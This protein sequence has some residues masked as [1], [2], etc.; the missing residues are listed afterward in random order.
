[1]ESKAK[2]LCNLSDRKRSL[3]FV[4]SD[5]GIAGNYRVRGKDSL[6][7]VSLLRAPSGIPPPSLS[8]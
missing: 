1:M 8:S 6:L 7:Y 2:H 3:N 5:G 4:N